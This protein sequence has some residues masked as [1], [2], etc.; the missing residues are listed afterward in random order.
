MPT[1]DPGLARLNQLPPPDA[2]G[3]L[4]ACCAAPV[5]LD[6]MVTGRPYPDRPALLARGL[7]TLA[8]LDWSQVRQAV[9]AHPRIGERV[10]G[11]GVEAAWS[12][13]EQAGMEGSGSD[14][15]AAL[16]EA[17]RAYENRFGHTFLIFATGRTDAEMLAAAQARLANSDSD[18]QAVVRVELAR[19]VSLR[20]NRMLDG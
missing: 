15:R 16:A 10:A 20:L 8:G 2:A 5:W 14:L 18:E 7:A 12:R 6:R 13:R 19:I 11:D 9:D 17:N 3:A 1:D 4:R